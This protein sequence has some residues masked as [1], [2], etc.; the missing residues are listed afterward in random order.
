MYPDLSYILHALIGTSPDNGAS[1]VKTFGLLL[2]IAIL[3]AAFML[4]RELRRKEKEGLLQPVKTKIIVGEPASPLSILLNGALGFFLFSKFVYAYQHFADFQLD[5]A[6][7]I[8]S[9]KGNLVAG[10]LGAVV[11]G[12]LKFWEKKREQLAKPVEKLLVVYPHDRIGDITIIAALAGVIGAKIF[13]MAEDF[14]TVLSGQVSFGEFMGQFL[15]GSGM[16]IYGGLIV[17]FFACFIYLRRFNIPPIHVMDAVAPALL[18][19]YGIG[20]LGCHLSGDGDWGIP[21]QELAENG[22]LIYNYVKPDWIPQWLWAQDYPHN[23][24]SEGVAIEGCEWRYCNRLPIPVFP[25]SIYELIMGVGLGGILWALRKRITIPGMLFFLYLVCNGFERFW[26][27]KI[28]V[29]DRY[30]ILGMQSTQAEFIAVI[31]MLIGIAGCLV[32]WQRGKKTNPAK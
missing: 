18:V 2:V 26:I 13:A 22:D 29:N 14:D 6:D 25:T 24:L 20:R 30:D 28:R 19:A 7:I 12:A 21:I 32:L 27:E 5:P 17:A 15:S 9:M 11:F 1:V 3:V 23:V 8:L 10:L 16:A 4:E 31:L